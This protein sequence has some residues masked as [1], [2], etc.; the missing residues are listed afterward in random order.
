MMTT[1]TPVK[2]T[3]TKSTES[4]TTTKQQQQETTATTVKTTTTEQQN[5]MKCKTLY[6]FLFQMPKIKNFNEKNF[7]IL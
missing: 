6:H 3:T 1:K 4:K 5:T 2:D 7:Q